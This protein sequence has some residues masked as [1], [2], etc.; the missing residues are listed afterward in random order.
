MRVPR[1]RRRCCTGCPASA[2]RPW[3]CRSCP[4]CRSASPGGPGVTASASRLNCARA[5]G[6]CRPAHPAP[7]AR[8]A[9]CRSRRPSW[10][11]K[12][13]MC[14]SAGT[15]ARIDAIF[16][17][18]SGRG[19]EDR[20]RAGIVEQVRNLLGRQRRVDR[21]VGD[22]RAQARVV[23]NQPLRA[24]LRQD[25]HPIVRH[26]AEPCQARARVR[27]TR[28]RIV[29]WLIGVHTPF[30]LYVSASAR[31]CFSTASKNSALIV[32]GAGR[33]PPF[34]YRVGDGMPARRV[35]E[36]RVGRRD[37]GHRMS[38]ARA[39][40]QGRMSQPVSENWPRQRPGREGCAP[41]DG[42]V[43]PRA[44][45]GAG[46]IRE[47]SAANR[48]PAALALVGHRG[49]HHHGVGRHAGGGK[50]LRAYAHP[51]AGDPDASV[52]SS[53]EAR[54]VSS[55]RYTD[56]VVSLVAVRRRQ[57]ARSAPATRSRSVAVADGR[58]GVPRRQRRRHGWRCAPVLPVSGNVVVNSR[59]A[60]WRRAVGRVGAL[61]DRDAT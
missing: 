1:A 51:S 59:R 32:P 23:G 50:L 34:E 54:P 28:S 58:C 15:C 9:S 4:T 61:R 49:P 26:H 40:R 48:R 57:R 19:H 30:T 7:R 6:R 36:R 24:I 12:P 45:D 42:R 55:T 35:G 20:L 25:A 41:D 31:G 18:W 60:I 22:R 13:M 38:P 47:R 14:V 37:E 3:D 10:R 52:V 27:R 46:L 16:F 21:H 33:G 2:S 8:P 17:A 56:F 11:A 5:L 39:G 53:T 43:Q 44:P 29:A